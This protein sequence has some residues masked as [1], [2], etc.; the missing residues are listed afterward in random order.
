[1]YKI[2]VLDDEVEMLEFIKDILETKGYSV[3][4][5][6]KP[7]DVLLYDELNSFDLIILD[8]MMPGID[9]FTFFKE[10]REVVQTPVMFLSAADT[11]SSMIKGLNLGAED[12]LTKPFSTKLLLAKISNIL[13]RQKKAVV[14]RYKTHG[15]LIDHLDRTA[16]IEGETVDLSKTEF[17]IIAILSLQMDKVFT[18][19]ELHHRL[20]EF[21][22]ES[23]I[24]VITQY[25]YQV[26]K[27]LKQYGKFPIKSVW[28]V[29][30][31]WIKD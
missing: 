14:N 31:K 29:G 21:D 26:R 24:R 25:I 17:D 27:K 5:S 20:L 18:H 16:S 1:M 8:V 7:E 22:S 13:M 4:T 15:I 23:E 3:Y 2:L 12:Y 19:E 6:G 10:V 9:G 30:Y 11:E 28:G